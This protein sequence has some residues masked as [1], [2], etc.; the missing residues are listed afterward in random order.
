MIDEMKALIK[1]LHEYNDAYYNRNVSLISDYEYDKKYDRLLEI[2]KLTGIVFANSPS[3]TVGAKVVDG[4]NKVTHNHPMLS[5]DKTKNPATIQTF[6]QHNKGLAMLKMDGLTISLHYLHGELVAAETRGNGAVGEDVLHTVKEF[7]NVPLHIPTTQEIIVDGEAIVDYETF[8]EINSPLIEKAKAEAANKKLTGKEFDN[9]VKEHTFK[10]PRNLASGSVRQLNGNIARDRKLQFVAW[11]FVK[12]IEDT[13]F[14]NRLTMLSVLGF[15]VVPYIGI[16]AGASID[17]LNNS[18]NELKHLASQLYYPIDGIVFSYDDTIYG[19]SLGAT[20]HHVRSQMAFKFYDEEVETTLKELEWSLG[21]T[22]VLTPVALFEPVEI[23]GTTVE[24]ASVHNVSVFKKL[25]LGIGDNI[26]VYKANQIIP[27]ISE[28][29]SNSGTCEIPEVC[30]VCGAKTILIKV[31]DSE[32]LM[33]SNPDCEGKMLNKICNFVSKAGMDIDG[34]SKKS[35]DKLIKVGLVNDYLDIY[36]LSIHRPLLLTMEGFGVKKV[37]KLLQAIED[38]KKVSLEN[39]LC[40]LSIHGLGNSKCKSIS[41]VFEGNFERFSQAMETGYN[42]SA[43]EDFGEVINKS[44]HD[45][46]SQNKSLVYALA[47]I[48]EWQLPKQSFSADLKDYTFV[49]TG[50]LEDFSRE[51]LKNL[52]ISNGGRVSGT[53]SAKTSFLI[54]NDIESTSSKNLKAKSLGIPVISEKDFVKKFLKV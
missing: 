26:L 9:Y 29:L 12:G 51:E 28:N 8:D 5:L 53:V 30:P 46:W 47:D 54:N 2:E 37:D 16:S 20:G 10:N 33:C 36:K 17:V 35:I 31:N 22:G 39:F 42:F 1:E 32:V 34:L 48:M 27:Q 41:K 18:I 23:D 38:S 43:L 49:I 45:Y 11:K 21:K 13:S 44:L 14:V 4:L 24:R 52:I 15:D 19:D 40:A 50:T 7:I 25:Q 6:F 3:M